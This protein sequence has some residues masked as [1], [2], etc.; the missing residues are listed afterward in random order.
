MSKDNT[1]EKYIAITDKNEKEVIR[2]A[3]KYRLKVLAGEKEGKPIYFLG[4]WMEPMMGT[5]YK[6]AHDDKLLAEKIPSELIQEL[7]VK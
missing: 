3:K 6:P 7:E 4:T 2:L 1:T 5:I